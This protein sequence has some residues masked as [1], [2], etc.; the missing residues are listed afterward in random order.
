MD[1]KVNNDELDTKPKRDEQGIVVHT[2]KSFS[3]TWQHNSDM[4]AKYQQ[5]LALWLRGLERKKIADIVGVAPSMISYWG[6]KYQWLAIQNAVMVHK[7]E[8]TIRE[9]TKSLLD[10]TPKINSMVD[11]LLQHGI[12]NIDT[13][14]PSK[15]IQLA[16]ELDKVRRLVNGQPTAIVDFNLSSFAEQLKKM[17]H[18]TQIEPIDNEL[19]EMKQNYQGEFEEAK[20][21]AGQGNNVNKDGK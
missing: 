21:E 3:H 1:D 4:D 5:A 10:Q 11:Q 8:C 13:I 7:T 12:A 18:S 6:K 14:D 9:R 20:S 19:I 17:R 2:E 15:A 16:I